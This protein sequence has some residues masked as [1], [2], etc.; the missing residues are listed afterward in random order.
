MK[1]SEGGGRRKGGGKEGRIKK[2]KKDAETKSKEGFV[3][4]EEGRA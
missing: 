4:T 3:C 2:A 1:N